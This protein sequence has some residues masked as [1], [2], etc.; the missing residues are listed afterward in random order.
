MVDSLQLNNSN[1]ETFSWID[2]EHLVAVSRED[3]QEKKSQARVYQIDVKS[4]K[5]V[6][7]DTIVLPY[8][9]D[10]FWALHVGLVHVDKDD[11]WLAY[12]FF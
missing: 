4:M 8:A 6:R 7:Q 12:S 5:I 11:L 2:D 1:F 10:E 9:T 3:V